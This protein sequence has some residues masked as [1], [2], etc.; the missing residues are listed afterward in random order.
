M[1]SS[2]LL[3]ISLLAALAGACGG[4]SDV[5]AGTDSPPDAAPEMRDTGFAPATSGTVSFEVELIGG[6]HAGSYHLTSAD[7]CMA[8]AGENG[9]LN[10][11]ALDDEA[12]LRYAQ[13]SI[14]DFDDGDG[15]S[16]RLIFIAQTPPYELR[17]NTDPN[18]IVATSGSGRV[19]WEVDADRDIVIDV[20]GAGDDGV[21]VRATITCQGPS[22]TGR[23]RVGA[24]PTTGQDRRK[25][26]PA[27]S[28]CVNPGSAPGYRG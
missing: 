14:Y 8:I 9:Q 23:R 16:D 21:E 28:T 24:R 7:R 20:E 1:K 12:A 11:N 5:P 4:G 2:Q 15:A 27:L 3:S 26:S 22:W 19:T 13:V 25:S 18:S 17:L 6:D 10:V